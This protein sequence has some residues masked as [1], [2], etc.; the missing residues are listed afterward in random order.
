MLL[1]GLPVLGSLEHFRGEVASQLLVE[2]FDLAKA[3]GV[4][5]WGIV[6]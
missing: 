3:F 1:C 6:A 5:L 4:E 2:V